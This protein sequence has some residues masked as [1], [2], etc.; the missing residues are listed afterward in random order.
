MRH[1]GDYIDSATTSRCP[2]MPCETC[3]FMRCK[4]DPCRHS[5]QVAWPPDALTRLLMEADGVTE[6]A[7]DALLRR[8]A[9]KSR[10]SAYESMQ[11]PGGQTASDRS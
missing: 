7:L 11:N 9:R 2:P 1:E 6:S 4:L 8:V 3:R 5:L 10:D